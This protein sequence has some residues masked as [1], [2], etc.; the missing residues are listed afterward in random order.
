MA[1]GVLPLA[2]YRPSLGIMLFSR[3]WW[4]GASTEYLAS[5]PQPQGQQTTSA[6]YIQFL[7]NSLA[8]GMYRTLGKAQPLGNVMF[9]I[10]SE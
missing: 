1:V 5:L 8:V 6:P 3:S 2:K 7:A 9:C 4:F 10:V